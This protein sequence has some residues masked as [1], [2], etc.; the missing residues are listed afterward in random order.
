MTNH[1]PDLLAEFRRRFPN[2]T[3]ETMTNG[4]VEEIMCSLCDPFGAHSFDKENPT[5]IPVSL[6]NVHYVTVEKWHHLGADV[7]WVVVFRPVHMH[8]SGGIRY[9]IT[10]H[11]WE[12]KFTSE[13]GVP[14]LVTGKGKPDWPLLDYAPVL[15]PEHL[16]RG[17]FE[18]VLSAAALTPMLKQIILNVLVPLVLDYY[19]DTLGYLDLPT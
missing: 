6:R 7:S 1:Y 13:T 10:F 16:R 18:L 4:H 2:I 8:L 5:F 3:S 11:T 17:G 14:L 19:S 9:T 15:Y 12:R